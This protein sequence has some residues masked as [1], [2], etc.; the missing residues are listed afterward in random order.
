MNT[1]IRNWTRQSTPR[2][3]FFYAK[4]CP[5]I[6]PSARRRF[7]SEPPL[8]ITNSE[9]QLILDQAKQPQTSVSLQALMRTG[10]GEFLHKTFAEEEREKHAATQLVLIQVASFLR[11]ELPIRLAHRI[12]DLEG[13]PILRDMES[14][15]A[16][17]DLYIKSFLEIM[18]FDNKIQTAE[19]EAAFALMLENIYE[20]H[21]KV[22]VQ[23][24]RGAYEFRKAVREEKGPGLELEE[25]IHHFL[26][27]FYLCR[28]GIRVLI[29]QY[30]ALR[31]P[32]VENYVGIICS[33]T[34]PYE[35]VKRAIGTLTCHSSS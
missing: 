9:Q 32:P 13:V 25:E 12:Q 3:R 4:T 2:F 35:I 18:S 26:D 30:L 6:S 34:S 17:R 19:Q 29:G 33:K 7:S 1:I 5:S 22:L 11:R 15:L 24:A 31:Q 27:R 8:I 21:S 10:R 28:I 14:V 23:M 20:R 16:V